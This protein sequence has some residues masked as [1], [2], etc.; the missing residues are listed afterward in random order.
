MKKILIIA[1]KDLRLNSRIIRLVKSFS[2]SGF[3]TTVIS[4]GNPTSFERIKNSTFI[5]LK[6]QKRIWKIYFFVK[7]LFSYFKKY[8]KKNFKFIK[9]YNTESKSFSYDIFIKI[10]IRFFYFFNLTNSTDFASRVKK[11]ITSNFDFIIAHDMYSL[12]AAYEVN[13]DNFFIYDA[14]E[15]PHDGRNDSSFLFKN[16]ILKRIRDYEEKCENKIIEKTDLLLTVSDGLSKYLNKKYKT[17]KII[18][19]KNYKEYSKFEIS[20]INIRSILKIQKNDVLILYLNSIKEDEGIDKIIDVLKFLPPNYKL[21]CLG[22]VIEKD[23]FLKLKK[24]VKNLSLEKRCFFPKLVPNKLLVNYISSADIGIIPRINSYLNH[25][26]SLPNR[27]FEFI[28]ARIPIASNNLPDLSNFILKNR[29]G[30]IFDIYNEKN[31]ISTILK[32]NTEKK[33]F[34]RNINQHFLKNNWQKEYLKLEKIISKV[35]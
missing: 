10:L 23:Y 26:F 1:Y 21:S 13:N 27:L 11:K 9:S 28:A 7:Y 25:E 22:P 31:I 18:T 2:L 33:K 4:L 14:V 34:K 15:V 16:N 20:K 30:L 8:K 35:S 12:I 6:Y 32:L 3:N 24:K 19:L 5:E 17:K 29:I